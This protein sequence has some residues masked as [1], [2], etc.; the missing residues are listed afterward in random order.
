LT[1][2][3]R[4][5]DHDHDV[6]VFKNLINS[7]S[8]RIIPITFCGGAEYGPLFWYAEEFSLRNGT[9]TDGFISI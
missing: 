5:A 9:R 8:D 1:D 3:N 6:T 2:S 7:T 4:Y